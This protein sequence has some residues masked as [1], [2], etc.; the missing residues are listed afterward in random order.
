MNALT[1]ENLR[2]Q[3]FFM[4]VIWPRYRCRSRLEFKI[5][6]CLRKN[7]LILK[8]YGLIAFINQPCI[9]II[10]R[11][12]TSNCGFSISGSS[13]MSGTVLGQNSFAVA[14][15]AAVVNVSCST[16][17]NHSD[18]LLWPDMSVRGYC[19]LRTGAL[20]LFGMAYCCET[21]GRM[22]LRRMHLLEKLN[23]AVL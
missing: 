13:A 18:L 23:V 14:F 17:L 4:C 8:P 12:R 6:P 1:S 19:S 3:N 10:H 21:S 11:T 2:D 16:T 20:K 22:S 9:P 7:L 5:S 15:F